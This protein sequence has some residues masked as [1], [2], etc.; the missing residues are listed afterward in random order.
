MHMVNM[1]TVVSTKAGLHAG[2]LV[3]NSVLRFLQW[4]FCKIQYCTYAVSDCSALNF[5][6]RFVVQYTV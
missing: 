6:V 3:E 5:T 2:S 1:S 4:Y